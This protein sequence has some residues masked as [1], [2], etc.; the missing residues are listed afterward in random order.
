MQNLR[1]DNRFVNELPGDPDQTNRRRQVLGAA[2]SAVAPTPVADPRLVAHAR[3]VSE[4]LGIAEQDVLAPSFARV[5]SGNELLPG[6]APYAACYGGHQ[7]G[8]WAGQLGDGRAMS[9]G[10]VVNAAGERW[11]LQLKGAGPTP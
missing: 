3:E 1:F 5:F 9:L 11:E 7:F 6:M 10:E 4:L 2:W 8:N